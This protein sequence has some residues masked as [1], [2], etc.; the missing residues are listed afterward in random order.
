MLKKIY[1]ASPYWMK[2]II[3][4]LKSFQNF[5]LRYSG[6]FNFYFNIYKDNYYKSSADLFEFQKNE[7]RDLLLIC[8]KHSAWYKKKFNE[9]EIGVDDINKD[10]IGVLKKLPLLSK[11]DRKKFVEKIKINNPKEK[12][13]LVTHTSGTSGSPT[14]NYL[15]KDSVWRAMALWKRFHHIIGI[16][17]NDKQIRFS[18]NPIV[19]TN[20][21]KKPFWIYNYFEKQLFFSTYH[22]NH[23]NIK[24]F[25]LKYLA[26]KPLLLDGYPSAI[27]EFAKLIE[28]HELVIDHYP[29]AIVTTAETLY[30]Y[31]RTLIEKVFKC[32]VFNQYASSEGSPFITECKN[33]NLHINV[34]SGYFEFLNTKGEVAKKGEVARMIV[35]SFRNN[36]T[37]LL[38]YDIEDCVILPEEQVACDC[39]CKMPIVERIIGREDDLLLSTSGALIGMMAY[40]VFTYAKNITKGQIIQHKPLE[41]TLNIEIE[42]SF[43]NS[44]QNFIVDK[45]KSSLGQEVEVE[46]VVFDKIPLGAAGKFTT[47]KRNFKL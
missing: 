22:I 27:Y 19:K 26:F 11:S 45:V 16:E 5:R 21:R 9:L 46:V 8:C 30:E 28:K 4:N 18:G 12:V 10:P 7:I 44:D 32:K 42:S 6:K 25:T 40:K 33:G 20:K 47:V 2:V 43:T 23:K 34:D 38:R 41:V 14:I 13:S 36:M 31:Q 35:T 29:T 15:N 1:D 24:E 17:S 3:F 39:G 37:P